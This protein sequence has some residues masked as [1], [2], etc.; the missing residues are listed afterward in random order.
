MIDEDGLDARLDAAIA[1]AREAGALAAAMRAGP[2]AALAVTE[3][4][5]LDLCTEA[6]RA[7]ERLLR[8]KL[9]DHFGDAMLGEEYGLGGTAGASGQLTGERLWV[10]DPI[11]G[12]FNFVHGLPQWAVSIGFLDAGVPTL[13]VVYHVTADE[14]FVARRGAGA[15]VNGAPIQVSGM[16]HADRPLIELGWSRRRSITPYLELIA[17]LIGED[18]EFRRLGSAAL[19][20]AQVA[21]GRTDAYVEFHINAWDIAAGL[22]L[23]REAGGWTSDFLAGDGLTRGNP[24]LACTP[25][26]QARLSALTG[27]A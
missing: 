21:A 5:V 13:G 12:T 8:T 24:I 15:T 25:G 17:K 26:L 4:G 6:D 20:L 14:L 1:A 23:V 18:C 7:V 16:R 19:G 10:V 2:E 9:A 3:K 22:V 27:I 11:D